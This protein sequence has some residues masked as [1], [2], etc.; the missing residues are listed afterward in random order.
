MNKPIKAYAKSIYG[1]E[2]QNLNEMGHALIKIIDA[3]HGHNRYGYMRV[4]AVKCLGLAWE[5]SHSDSVS[6]SHSS[7][8]GYSRNWSCDKTLPKGFPGWQGRVWVRYT[9]D[10][11]NSFGSDPFDR[12]LTYT[13]TGGDGGYDGPW[14]TIIHTHF[15]RYGHGKTDGMYPKINAYSWDFKIFDYDWPELSDVLDWKNGLKQWEKTVEKEWKKAVKEWEN[16]VLV[17]HNEDAMLAKLEDRWIR[18]IYPP[19]R[20]DPPTHPKHKFFWEDAETKAN[21]EIFM[22]NCQPKDSANFKKIGI[23][24]IS[25]WC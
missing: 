17:K 1:P 10:F 20:P 16:T 4:S 8:E 21:D 24:N 25:K 22:M 18:P 14:S 2:P 6:N 13:G 3:Y 23:D 9:N 19:S 12:T 15:N 5:I 11:S 7:P